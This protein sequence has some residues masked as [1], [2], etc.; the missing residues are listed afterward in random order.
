VNKT[1]IRIIKRKDAEIV[2]DVKAQNLSEQKLS[3]E[4]SEEKI[5][6]R[7]RRKM[8]DEVSKWIAERRKNKRSEEISAFRKLFGDEFLSSRLA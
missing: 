1:S 2:E 8:A 7:L 5:E 4:M 3:V 6:S